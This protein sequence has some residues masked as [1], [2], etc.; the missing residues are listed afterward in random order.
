MLALST[1]EVV[2]PRVRRSVAVLVLFVLVG[3]A[4]GCGP[5]S[6]GPATAERPAVAVEVAPVEAGELAESIA[7]VG[8]LAPKFEGEVK[9]EYSGV[10]SDVFV[11]E[12]VRVERGTLLAR[13]DSREAQ[14]ALKAARASRLEA[15]V[16]V[17]RAKR[18]LERCVKLR[19]AGLATQQ[20]LDDARSAA[21]AAEAMHEAA[22]ARE[23][24]SRTRLSKAEIR[25]PMSGVIASRTVHPGDF[26]E[27]MGSPRPMFTIVDNRRLELTVSV[28][29]SA[30]ASLAVGQPLTFTV[31]AIPQRVFEGEV[32][33]VN[34][35]VDEASRT[36]K[37]IAQVDNGDGA[38]KSGLFARGRIVTSSRADVLRVARNALVTWDPTAGA[39]VVYVVE[40]GH[41]KRRDVATGASTGS[42]VEIR[43]G[44]AAGESV[45]T[46]GAFD[47]RDG[48]R[49]TVV[50]LEQ[51]AETRG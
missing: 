48:D 36:L 22:A 31:D 6:T 4:A 49:V 15:E 39:G 12:W 3:L 25:A 11:T 2:M 35:A 33:F 23:E 50:S 14:A 37:V 32:S 28:P 38:L 24:L 46:R 30:I 43:G 26:V 7:V 10:I 27:N 45:V 21:E 34:P 42:A 18:E 41:A 5:A 20:T 1:G 29:S 9:A 17:A 44:L 19:A 51:S 16:G 40:N 8:T 13:F 47:V